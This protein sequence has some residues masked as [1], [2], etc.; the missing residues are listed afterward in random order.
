MVGNK[1]TQ[2]GG[3]VG[4]VTGKYNSISLCRLKIWPT[5]LPNTT[6]QAL[7]T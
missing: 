1:W 2:L 4:A 7:T 6:L 3:I 5:V